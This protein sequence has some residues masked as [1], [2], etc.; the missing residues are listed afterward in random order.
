MTIRRSSAY[1]TSDLYYLSIFYAQM[2]ESKTP[3]IARVFNTAGATSLLI[4]YVLRILIVCYMVQPSNRDAVFVGF[5]NGNMR[6]KAIRCCAVPML[7]AWLDEY[8]I[9]RAN[10]LRQAAPTRN[11]PNTVSH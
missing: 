11:Q 1:D 10:L 8:Y 5:L 4:S 2:R 3:A 9:A 7:F 6:H